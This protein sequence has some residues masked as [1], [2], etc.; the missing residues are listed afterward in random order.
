MPNYQ[1]K[2]SMGALKE[3]NNKAVI[4]TIDQQIIQKMKTGL[5]LLP[6]MN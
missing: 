4:I 3:I 2:R 5:N 6:L 1:I